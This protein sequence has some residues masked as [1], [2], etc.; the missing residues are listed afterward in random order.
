MFTIVSRRANFID[1]NV[2]GEYVVDLQS[3]DAFTEGSFP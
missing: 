3:K 1:I 2:L